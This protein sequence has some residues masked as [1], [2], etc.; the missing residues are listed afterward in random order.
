MHDSWEVFVIESK[1]I[2]VQGDG[3]SGQLHQLNNEKSENQNQARSCWYDLVIDQK[4][5]ESS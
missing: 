1:N 2:V 5:T 3:A 4:S